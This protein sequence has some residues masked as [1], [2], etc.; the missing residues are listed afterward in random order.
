MFICRVPGGLVVRLHCSHHR[1]LGLNPGQGTNPSHW[2]YTDSALPVPGQNLDLIL[3]RH[4]ANTFINI[5]GRGTYNSYRRG[6]KSQAERRS[7]ICE[8]YF[9][10]RVLARRYGPQFAY[11]KY[12][13]DRQGNSRTNDGLRY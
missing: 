13:G 8:E 5:P 12:F 3:S 6:F 9:H 7:E 10:C 2:S 11:Q 1:G 4:R